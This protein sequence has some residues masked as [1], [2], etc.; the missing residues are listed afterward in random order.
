MKHVTNY[1]KKNGK[2]VKAKN[3]GRPAGGAAPGQN[4]ADNKNNKPDNPAK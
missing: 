2:T 3:A 4:G 1:E